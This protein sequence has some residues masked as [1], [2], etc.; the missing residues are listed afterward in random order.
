MKLPFY[1][2][3]RYFFSKKSA[4]VINLISVIA[5]L[6][7]S[8]GTA[9]LII[10]LSVFNGFEQMARSML[11]AFNPDIKIVA[12][13]GKYFDKQQ[14]VSSLD[15]MQGIEAYSFVMQDNA[16]MEY[17]DRQYIGYVKGVDENFLKVTGIDTMM[18]YGDFQLYYK[19]RPMA[20]VG[21]GIA[22][23]LGVQLNFLGAI[24]LWLPRPEAKISFDITQMFVR[25]HIFPSGIFSVH[26]DFDSKYIFVPLDFLQYT[27]GLDTNIVSAAEIKL[28]NADAA[29]EVERQ[30]G[31]KLGKDFRVM[32]RYEQEAL[33]YKIVHS[34]RLAVI[35]IL[36]FIVIIASFNVIATISMLIIDKRKDIEILN[37]LGADKTML[38]KIFINQGLIINGFGVLIGL[39][40]GIGLV[41]V[42][43]Y[44]G[45]LEFP[46][47][48]SLS[49]LYYPVELRLTDIAIT[50]AIVLFI[51]YFASVLPVRFFIEKYFSN[52]QQG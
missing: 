21:A 7:I 49:Y 35:L 22:N 19:G 24:K 20:V 28:T 51:G 10:V 11:N 9:A 42:Q 48:T 14:V 8:F 36:T 1:I 50:L 15:N 27:L 37:F 29:P 52:G 6:G 31:R 26:Q 25:T 16:L 47:V 32:D 38:K 39:I 5:L 34:E 2:A 13:R 33:F 18:I 43:K 30:L 3:R 46:S 23:S 40:F 4:N 41:M 45:I 44:F 17:E 12:A